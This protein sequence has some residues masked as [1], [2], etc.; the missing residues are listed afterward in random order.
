M[1]HFKS[2]LAVFLTFCMLGSS[3]AFCQSLKE[4]E[5]FR[6]L[7]AEQGKNNIGEAEAFVEY[8]KELGPTISTIDLPGLDSIQ[9]DTSVFFGYDFLNSII[10]IELFNNFPVPTHYILGPGDEI[11]VTLWDETGFR[12]TREISR[13]N[14]IYIEW[15]GILNLA[16]KAVKDAETYL[17]G[18]L[19]KVY[20][21]LK[22][23][24]SRTFIDITGFQI[25]DYSEEL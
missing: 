3:I 2:G 18:H 24:N 13:D 20:S 12:I 1:K 11:V 8:V 7:I 5:K 22:G 25:N 17:K 10:T 15:V 23:P 21:T 14:S 19:G 6:K 4:I 16:R 9:V